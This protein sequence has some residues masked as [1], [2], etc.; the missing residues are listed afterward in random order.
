MKT[1]NAVTINFTNHQR[2]HNWHKPVYGMYMWR[3]MMR[4]CLFAR[5]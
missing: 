3:K 1:T 2:Y 5:I 4:C